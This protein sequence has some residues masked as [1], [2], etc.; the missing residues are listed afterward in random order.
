MA[1]IGPGNPN[2]NTFEQ[3]KIGSDNAN[4]NA[5]LAQVSEKREAIVKKASLIEKKVV[6]QFQNQIFGSKSW[7]RASIH[8]EASPA[9]R[10][11]GDPKEAIVNLHNGQ[12]KM[13]DVDKGVQLE[14]VL[15]R[16]E[17]NFL[18]DG[19]PKLTENNAER[20]VLLY[21]GG[22]HCSSF[23]YANPLMNKFKAAGYDVLVVNRRG[24]GNSG[25]E[26]AFDSMKKD[27]ESVVDFL[28]SEGYQEKNMAVMGYSLGSVEASHVSS[29]KD[30][31]TLVIDRGFTKLSSVM[32]DHAPTGFKAIA[33]KTAERYLEADVGKSLESFKGKRALV[34]SGAKDE[35]MGPHHADR[36]VS[37][38]KTNPDIE[39]EHQHVDNLTHEEIK[40]IRS[41]Y[42]GMPF[43]LKGNS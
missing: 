20:P 26:P 6:K 25:G 23:Y 5:A 32:K 24:F 15:T 22:S 4:P 11:A 9:E 43:G 16:N 17:G 1:S 27:A 36:N 38:L 21:F 18:E 35:M 19:V 40:N 10:A 3:V 33:K 37:I 41:L 14:A 13:I 42:K 12:E 8:K 7:R 2:I 31:N 34:L 30:I 29:V 39:V 28:K